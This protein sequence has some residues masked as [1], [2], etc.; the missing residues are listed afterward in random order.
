[1]QRIHDDDLAGHVLEESPDEW[2]V[3]KVPA[4]AERRTVVTFPKTL[5]EIVREPGDILWPE[6]EGRAELDSVKRLL[7]SR[8]YSAQYQQEP[9][10]PA[11]AM[12]QTAWWR[13][14]REA[15]ANLEELMQSWDMTFKDTTGTDYVVGQVW[16][17]RGAEKYLLDQVRDRMDFPTTLTAVR[18]IT[19]KWPRAQLKLVEDKANGPAVIASLNAELGGFV[20]I[21]P[22]GGKVARVAAV[23]PAIEAGNVFLPDPAYV[24]AGDRSWVPDYVL[25]WSRFPA[26]T[27]DDQVDASS[28]ALNRWR[29]A[30]AGEIVTE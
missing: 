30:I 21:E 7:G 10:P 18:L 13:F 20:P 24:D 11:G 14:Y 16:G 19:A 25:E 22:D 26:G 23:S 6:R 9:A 28:Q 5:R 27:H 4:E 12:V 3:V 17:R 29:R 2:T 8:D 15:P 1:M